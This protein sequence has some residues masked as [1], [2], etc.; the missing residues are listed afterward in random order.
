MH[1]KSDED[2]VKIFGSEY[3]HLKATEK[4]KLICKNLNN[5]NAIERQVYF[6]LTKGTPKN[7]RF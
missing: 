2:L 3:P 5:L 7:Y 6:F 4:F 1:S